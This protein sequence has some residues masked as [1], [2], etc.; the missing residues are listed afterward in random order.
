MKPR[1]PSKPCPG[2][3]CLTRI[4]LDRVLCHFCHRG[5]AKPSYQPPPPEGLESV[6]TIVQR[7][8]EELPTCPCGGLADGEHHES[9]LLHQRYAMAQLGPADPSP[10]WRR[11]LS[12]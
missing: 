1:S 11:F 12:R 4:P 5:E 2:Y 7:F 6:T 9:S 10:Q 8:E 3:R